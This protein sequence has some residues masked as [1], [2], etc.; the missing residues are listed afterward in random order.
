MNGVLEPDL[1]IYK[2]TGQALTTT[3]RWPSTHPEQF[4]THT[5]HSYHYCCQLGCMA[6]YIYKLNCSFGCWSWL[7]MYLEVKCILY[8]KN[9]HACT[10]THDLVPLRHCSSLLVSM[11]V[12]CVLVLLNVDVYLLVW[13]WYSSPAQISQARGS[14]EREKKD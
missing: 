10:C 1:F 11:C 6:G 8:L 13:F 4:T 12:L 5:D 7:R 9:P 14:R 2:Q 3:K